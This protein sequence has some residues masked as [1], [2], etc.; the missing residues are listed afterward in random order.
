M[1]C[2][3]KSEDGLDFDDDSLSE[4]DFEPDFEDSTEERGDIDMED[5]LGRLN[6]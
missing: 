1:F 2:V 3:A 4:P 5:S 6:D